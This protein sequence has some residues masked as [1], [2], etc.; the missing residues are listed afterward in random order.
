[1]R[2][3]LAL[4][5]LLAGPLAAQQP[6]V[7]TYGYLAFRN[8]TAHVYRKDSAGMS[9]L[10]IAVFSRASLGGRYYG[11]GYGNVAPMRATLYAGAL[12]QLAAKVDSGVAIVDS[13]VEPQ[14]MARL[15]C[16]QRE[17]WLTL[18]NAGLVDS[19]V[20]EPRFNA[21][22]MVRL[23]SALEAAARRDSTWK[24]LVDSLP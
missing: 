17:C 16:V 15:H 5:V 7:R 10:R 24:P 6:I 9:A 1:V 22:Q 11:A 3:T 18:K 12:R 21:L 19:L 8:A 2:L 20:T 13:L 14:R 23:A 4:L